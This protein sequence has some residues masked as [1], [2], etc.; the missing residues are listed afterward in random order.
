MEKRRIGAVKDASVANIE[1][2]AVYTPLRVVRSTGKGRR[3]L[4][5]L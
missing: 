2:D 1:T 3:L 5:E 4:S